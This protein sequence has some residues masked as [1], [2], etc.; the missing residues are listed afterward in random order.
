MAQGWTRYAPLAGVVGAILTV[1]AFLTMGSPPD[2]MD[3]PA[4]IV[5]YIQDDPG[6]LQAGLY[7]DMLSGVFILWFVGALRAHLRNHEAEGGGRLSNLAFGGA[8]AAQA[9]FWVADGVMFAAAARAGE[10]DT[11][12][13]A[14]ATSLFDAYG[15]IAFIGGALGLA[16]ALGA[17]AVVAMRYRAMPSWLAWSTALLALL[18]ASPIGFFGVY[19]SILWVVVTSVWLF[20]AWSPGPA[21]GT[22]APVV[23]VGE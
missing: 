17:T 16:V 19:I 1:V 22:A 18:L 14:V 6:K 7:L 10:D 2:Y 13:Q 4:E 21:A 3:K 20:R 5:E 12:N 23:T 8:I 11:I 15:S 9:C